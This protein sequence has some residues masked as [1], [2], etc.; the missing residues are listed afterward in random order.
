MKVKK[1]WKKVWNNIEDFKEQIYGSRNALPTDSVFKSMQFD[2]KKDEK[3][4]PLR[5]KLLNIFEID[6]K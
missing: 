3:E 6:L 2:Q 1:N 4:Q 5:W